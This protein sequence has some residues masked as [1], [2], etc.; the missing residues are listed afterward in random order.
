M[1]LSGSPCSQLDLVTM[2]FENVRSLLVV[3]GPRLQKLTEE[4]DEEQGN[5]SVISTWPGTA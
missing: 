4:C 2:K 3:V 1:G 5:G